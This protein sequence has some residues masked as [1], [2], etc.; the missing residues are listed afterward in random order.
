MKKR[1]GVEALPLRCIGAF[2]RFPRRSSGE[3]HIWMAPDLCAL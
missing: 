3:A 2:T 1:E